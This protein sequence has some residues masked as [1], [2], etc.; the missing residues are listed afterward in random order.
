[1]GVDQGLVA[2]LG[3][4]PEKGGVN[5]EDVNQKWYSHKKENFNKLK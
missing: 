1:M 3:A 2:H 4:F 5:K